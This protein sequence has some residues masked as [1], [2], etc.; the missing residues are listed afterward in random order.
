M[1]RLDELG[2]VLAPTF[3]SRAYV[4]YLVEQGIRPSVVAIL[5]GDEWGW[6]GP[7]IIEMRRSQGTVPF[8]FRATEP[9]RDTA[10]A[11]GWTVVD[12]P[13][14][15][16]NS[17]ATIARLGAMDADVLL[18]SGFSKV[19]VSKQLIATGKRFLHVHG[20][21][22]PDFRG[23]TGHYF[24]LLEQGGLGVTA[25]WL[26]AEVDAGAILARQWYRPT[27]GVD[28]D[29]IQDPVAR[30]YLLG[31]VLNARLR[32]GAY[33]ETDEPE[34]GTLHYVI[35]PVLKSLALRPVVG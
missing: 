8:A 26:N 15:N 27:P 18:Y 35:H 11:A 29:Y 25:I 12:L 14:A 16:V 1:R 7:S 6:K 2:L 31:E 21:Y 34:V 22:L 5:P 30:A 23:A 17:A 28:V 19:L 10:A 24:G 32:D 20:G 4:Q 33:P 13:D 3:R 9:A